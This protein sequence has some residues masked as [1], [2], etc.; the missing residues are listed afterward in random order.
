MTYNEPKPTDKIIPIVC[1]VVL[2]AFLISVPFM[3]RDENARLEQQW[4]EQGC[5]MYDDRYPE[6]LPAKCSNQ[7]IDH[8]A[9][10]EQRVQPPEEK[11]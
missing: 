8:Y 7:F 6:K 2:L 4:Q 9:P 10:Q 5:H 3:I 1:G 11:L